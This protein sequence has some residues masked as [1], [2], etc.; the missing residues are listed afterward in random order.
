[1]ERKESGQCVDPEKVGGMGSGAVQASDNQGSSSMHQ[2]G[3]G[4]DE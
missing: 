3:G 1:M 4:E 2:E